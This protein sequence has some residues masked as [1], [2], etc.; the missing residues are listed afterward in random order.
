LA[1]THSAQLRQLMQGTGLLW[2]EV[3]NLS[4]EDSTNMEALEELMCEE[5]LGSQEVEITAQIQD[6]GDEF[7]NSIDPF[8]WA[9]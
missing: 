6:E 3:E 7:F 4:N 2:S 9:A 8:F 5:W 1:E